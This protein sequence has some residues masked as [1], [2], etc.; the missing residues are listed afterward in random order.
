MELMMEPERTTKAKILAERIRL[1]TAKAKIAVALV[2][3]IDAARASIHAA[4]KRGDD[5]NWFA[6][7]LVGFLLALFLRFVAW[8]VFH[9]AP[10]S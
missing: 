4:E 10:L 7:G 2:R 5:C 1:A 9:V 3:K 8:K 6:I